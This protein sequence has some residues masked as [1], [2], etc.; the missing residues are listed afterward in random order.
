MNNIFVV[1]SGC[2]TFRDAGT[3]ALSRFIIITDTS[4]SVNVENKAAHE[5]QSHLQQLGVS[6]D[7]I[8]H[9]TTGSGSDSR[10]VQVWRYNNAINRQERFSEIFIMSIVIAH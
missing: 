9:G 10:P 2:I 8:C 5:S 3:P 6:C 1:K 7:M 4:E